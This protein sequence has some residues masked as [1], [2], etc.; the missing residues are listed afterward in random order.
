MTERPSHTPITPSP[1]EMAR[2]FEEFTK[3]SEEIFWAF[4]ERY[5]DGGGAKPFDPAA[6]G[7]AFWEWNQKLLADPTVFFK[8]Q[9]QYW[10]DS[11]KLFRATQAKLAGEAGDTV[12]APD[13]GD[14]RFRDP[15]WNDEVVFDHLKQSYLLSARFV[16]ALVSEVRD[17]DDQT[18]EKVDFYTRRYI[19]SVAPTNFAATNPEVIRKTRETGGQ[20]LIDG[21]ENLLRDLERGQGELKITMSDREAF[22]VGE[23]LA[24]TP[25]AVVFENDL[26]QLI[27][28]NPST[29]AV[30]ERPLLIVPPWIN[31]YYALDLKSDNSM[32]KWLVDQGYT[33]F[34]I[35]WVNPGADLAHKGFDDYMLEGP[36]AAVDAIEKATGQKQVNVAG[37]CIGGTLTA[38]T[39][40]YLTATGDKRI[41]SATLMACMTD[42]S[43]AGELSVFIDDD[44][45]AA[46]KAVVDRR[47]YLSGDDMAGVVSLLRAN[48]LIWSHVVNNYLLGKTP[49][50]FDMVYWFQDSTRLPGKMITWY[51]ENIYHKNLLVKPGGVSLAGTP[52]DL[53]KIKTPLYFLS[54]EEDHICPWESTYNGA[55]TFEGP[56]TFVLG[57]SGHNAGVVNPPAKGKY[58][59]R[60]NPKR[61]DDAHT[62]LEGASQHD[63]SWWPHWSEWLAKR[64]GK[65]VAAR[66]PGEGELAI[67]EPAPG[68]YVM[69]S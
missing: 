11:A 48:D 67:I 53:S 12:I 10:E 49:M 14:R 63:G 19:E 36:I 45:L 30:H 43:D 41:A 68:R 61:P 8:A 65:Q 21:F 20:N 51:L 7:N 34:L 6:I 13:K 57:G 15:S 24:Y 56:V 25:G 1:A 42:F 23:N 5:R 60:T 66:R 40:A 64:S 31:K 37:Y 2:K 32:V 18:R 27:Q 54:A 55:K 38:T 22:T 29:E 46:L 33:V 62:W 9:R 17:L 26:M 16:H 52:I 28:Y 3:K 50:P 39:I 69:V 59:Y 44:Q 4:M 58:G 35:S 47:G